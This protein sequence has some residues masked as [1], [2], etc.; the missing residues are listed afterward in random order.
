MV[1]ISGEI[2]YRNFG[3]AKMVAPKFL[4]DS[5]T[6]ALGNYYGTWTNFNYVQSIAYDNLPPEPGVLARLNFVSPGGVS[7]LA[8]TFNEP[9]YLNGATLEFWIRKTAGGAGNFLLYVQKIAGILQ[10]YKTIAALPGTW[11]KYTVAIPD[12]TSTRQ[13]NQ[14]QTQVAARVSSFDIDQNIVGAYTIDIAGFTV[15]RL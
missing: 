2:N 14:S 12:L 7:G 6:P 9:Q 4:S 10:Y 8:F 15:R 1:I 13:G 5:L 3:Q 11:T